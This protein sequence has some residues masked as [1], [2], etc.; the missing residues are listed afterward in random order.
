MFRPI[1]SISSCGSSPHARGTPLVHEGSFLLTR[2]IPA[3]AG[4]AARGLNS[5]H[6]WTV[7][8]R[9]RGERRKINRHSGVAAGSSPHARGTRVGERVGN[10]NPRFIPACAG[11]ARRVSAAF[12]PTSVHPR[13]R[14]ERNPKDIGV[15]L[16]DGS[17]PHARGTRNIDTPRVTC[18][19]FIPACAGNACVRAY[20]PNN[21]TVHPRM[22]GERKTSDLCK[23]HPDGSSPHAR[24]TQAC[25]QCGGNCARFIPACAGNAFRGRL[26]PPVFNGSSPHARGTPV[27]GG[28]DCLGRRFIPACAGNARREL[29]L[30]DGATVH[31][32]MRGE[33]SGH[34]EANGCESGSSPH[35]RGTLRHSSQTIQRGRFI[36]ACAG[37]A[38]P[39]ATPP[40][41][42]AVHPRMR[43]ERGTGDHQD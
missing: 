15:M 13:M 26:A 39:G 19:R 35:A 43:G 17:S 3:C 5:R 36:P 9:M 16:Q 37:N 20:G 8:P 30:R 12:R 4:N 21:T 14:G 33:R 23:Q 1:S 2:F 25:R 29:F 6:R 32:R 38:R 7:H 42:V 11:N 31:P 28:V 34:A 41:S 18:S 10:R 27:P 22:R 40:G 24:G